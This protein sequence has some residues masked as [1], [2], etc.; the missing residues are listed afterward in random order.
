MTQRFFVLIPL[1]GALLL[2][3]RSARVQAQ[4]PD[5]SS[6]LAMVVID[7]ENQPI[8]GLSIAV[9][10]EGG[11]ADALH[12][13]DGAG[14]TVFGPFPAHTPAIVVSSAS[15]DGHP[16]TIEPTTLTDLRIGLVPG[17]ER[18]VLLRV[19]SD[20]LS[21]APETLFSGANAEGVPNPLAVPTPFAATAIEAATTAPAG[22][23][24]PQSPES[25]APHS[26]WSWLFIGI[27]LGPLVLVL[28]GWLLYQRRRYQQRLKGRRIP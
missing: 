14:T 10:A 16:L 24:L 27:A 5:A 28:I 4:Q 17:A 1:L 7:G 8:A 2:G 6:S 13:T 22:M 11:S 18:P 20:T 15:L 26:R 12:T 21:L 23:F 19:V 3:G 9:R 25:P